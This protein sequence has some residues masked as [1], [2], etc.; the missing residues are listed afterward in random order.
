MKV[1]GFTFVKNAS[2]LYIPVKPSIESVLPL[3]DEF[4]VLLGDSDE[5]DTTEQIIRS[6]NSPKIKVHRS[7]W[8]IE[9]YRGTVVFASQTDEAKDLCS[10]DW[11][12]YIQSDEVLHEKY[13]DPIRQ[14][15]KK[16]H[17]VLEV[18]GFLFSYKHFW[19]DYWHYHDSYAWY[20]REIRVIRN[21]SDIHSWRDAQSFRKYTDFNYSMEDYLGN[22]NSRKLNVIELDA[23]IYHYGGSRPPEVMTQ[24]RKGRVKDNFGHDRKK[25]GSMLKGLKVKYD[26]GP[27]NRLKKF[28][29]SHPKVMEEWIRDFYW[30]DD[31]QYTGPIR[32]DRPKFKHEKMRYK[33]LT[34]LSKIRPFRD[35]IGF[36][37]YKIIG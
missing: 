34:P 4:I 23:E 12:F 28:D 8:D 7:K 16:F 6:I 11:L 2:K 26:Y 3:V 37:N 14:S 20:P 19:G 22:K 24:K 30:K 33:L 35:T 9:K 27:L 36:K 18:E 25:S 31:L 15:M 29:Q 21:D 17:D 1:S 5:D 10:G 32:N 13:L